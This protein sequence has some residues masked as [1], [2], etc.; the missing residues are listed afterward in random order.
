MLRLR[1]F[2]VV[3]PASL[4]E[5]TALLAQGGGRARPLAGGTGLLPILKLG[6]QGPDL[7]VSLRA[8]PD[9]RGIGVHDGALR[10]GASVALADLAASPAV[11]ATVPALAEAAGRVG[12]PQVRFMGTLGGNLCLDTRCRYVDQ[13]ELVRE[14]WGGCLKAGGTRC[15]VVPGGQSC[16]AA[17]SSDTAAVLVALDAEAEVVGPGGARQVPVV[18]LYRSDGTAHL[19]LGSAEVLVAVRVPAPPPTT[20]VGTRKWAVRRSIDF[21]LV[22]VAIRL[23]LDGGDLLAGG[24]L[25][26]TVLGPRPRVVD[27]APLRGAAV[28][29]ELAQAV[30]DLAHR[31]CKPLP[32]IPTDPDYRRIR[33][34]VE[35]CRVVRALSAARSPAGGA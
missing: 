17:L 13:G 27:L 34:A 14:A 5:A 22:S 28:G 20:L 18:S 29:E 33:L 12:S 24:R 21:P 2:D 7:L 19:A 1:P 16:V 6:R 11:R 8:I 25:V 26:A 35:A 31:Q 30:K 23:D 3:T 15:H 9:L 10:I 4:E 32:N